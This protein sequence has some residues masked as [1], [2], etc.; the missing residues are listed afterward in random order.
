MEAEAEEEEAVE[1]EAVEEEV[2]EEE[3]VEEEVVEDRQFHSRP[4]HNRMFCQPQMLRQW[5]SFLT[6][7][8]ETKRRQKISSKK[9]KDTSILTKM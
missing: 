7:L 4:N 3:V 5:E 8:M 9:S 6:R 1:V 2:A